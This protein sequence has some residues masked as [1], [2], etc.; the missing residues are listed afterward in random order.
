M[1]NRNKDRKMKTSGKIFALVCEIVIPLALAISANFIY[2]YIKNVNINKDTNEKDSKIEINSGEGN[3]I[4]QGNGNTIINNYGKD[5]SDVTKEDKNEKIVMSETSYI[6]YLKEYVGDNILFHYYNDYD[7]DGTCEMF[8]L[9]GDSDSDKKFIDENYWGKIWYINC[10]GAM[11]IESKDVL[12]WSTPDVFLFGNY[13][14]VTFEEFYGTA[15][16]N[17]HIWGV[18]NGEPYQPNISGK[19]RGLSF[20][21]FNEIEGIDDEFDAG[22]GGDEPMTGHTWKPYYFYFDGKT[23]RE[24]GGI[25]IS[26]NDLLKIKG[27]NIILD[28]IH[29][30][31][32][33]ISSILYRENGVININIFLEEEGWITYRNI[34]LRCSEDGFTIIPY[35]NDSFDLGIY[36]TASIPAIATYPEKFPY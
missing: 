25:I 24:Y 36:K 17:T 22:K 9:V 14:F 7:G 20:N 29:N 27:T 13:S 30:S 18:Q 11:E 28:E 12:Y 23:F 16:T 1:Y 21:E 31:S 32:Y 3:T 35:S 33:N 26:E 4:L 15:G 2:D 19:I 5:S 34:N 10:D 8:A 6:E